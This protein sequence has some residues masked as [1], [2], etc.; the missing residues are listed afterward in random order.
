MRAWR[1][2]PPQEDV[3]PSVCMFGDGPSEGVGGGA[4]RTKTQCSTRQ[5]PQRRRERGHGPF[6]CRKQPPLL[7][8]PALMSAHRCRS[9]CYIQSTLTPAPQPVF[10]FCVTFIFTIKRELIALQPPPHRPPP[11]PGGGGAQQ[12]VINLDQSSGRRPKS[13]RLAGAASLRRTSTE[14][15][16]DEQLTAQW[17]MSLSRHCAPAATTAACRH[18]ASEWLR[19]GVLSQ[20]CRLPAAFGLDSRGGRGLPVPRPSQLSVLEV[21]EELRTDGAIC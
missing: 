19:H 4:V 5:N 10:A 15:T 16:E 21:V 9:S 8:G 17:N 3:V 7:Q 14:Q 2:K 20:F 18:S 12:R 11:P 1:L 6:L 13:N